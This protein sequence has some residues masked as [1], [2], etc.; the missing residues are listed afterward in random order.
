MIADIPKKGSET[1]SN[2]PMRG[3]ESA[4]FDIRDEVKI[5]DGRNIEFGKFELIA[6]VKASHEFQNLDVGSVLSIRGADWTV[7]G[8]F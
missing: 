5:V 4:S 6:G 8:T 7:V 2:L 1:T 3:V